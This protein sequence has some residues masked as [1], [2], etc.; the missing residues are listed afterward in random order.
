MAILRLEIGIFLPLALEVW[1]L[2][3]SRV[4]DIWMLLHQVKRAEQV[5][6]VSAGQPF[7]EDT[8]DL[9]ISGFG[10]RDRSS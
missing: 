2:D 8:W 1:D 5:L 7:V 4:P 10:V 6:Q 3:G 9:A